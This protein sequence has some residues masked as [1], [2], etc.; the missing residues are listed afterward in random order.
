MKTWRAGGRRLQSKWNGSRANATRH[1]TKDRIHK[2]M[3]LSTTNAGLT[4]PSGQAT[5]LVAVE[6]PP[7]AALCKRK[8]KVENF[9]SD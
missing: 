8:R 7:S 1:P 9:C 5:A 6:A 2:I 4:E 3:L